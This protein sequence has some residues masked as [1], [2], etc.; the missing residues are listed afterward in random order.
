ML[1]LDTCVL[2]ALLTPEVHSQ[3]TTAFVKAARLLKR[4]IPARA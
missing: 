3:S 4:P 1:N 2:L